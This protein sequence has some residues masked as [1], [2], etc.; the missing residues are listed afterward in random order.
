MVMGKDLSSLLMASS[1]VGVLTTGL[2]AT[3]SAVM[4]YRLRSVKESVDVDQ[5]SSVFV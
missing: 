1:L 5:I 3:G 4:Y 2:L